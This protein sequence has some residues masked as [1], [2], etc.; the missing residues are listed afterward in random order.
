MALPKFQ[1]AFFYSGQFQ[2]NHPIFTIVLSL[3]FIGLAGFGI[4]YLE[5]TVG[6]L[7]RSNRVVGIAQLRTIQATEREV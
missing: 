7:E 5:I 2:A 4:K 3:I 1:D 6:L